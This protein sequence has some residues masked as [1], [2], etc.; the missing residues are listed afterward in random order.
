MV[1]GVLAK[2]MGTSANPGVLTIEE[3]ETPTGTDLLTAEV[4]SLGTPPAIPA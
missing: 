2:A 1:L 4:L 3:G